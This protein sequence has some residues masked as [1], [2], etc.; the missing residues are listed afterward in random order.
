MLSR[1]KAFFAAFFAT[2][3]AAFFA[4]FFAAFRFFLR[5]ETLHQFTHGGNP[6]CLRF[7]ILH[8]LCQNRIVQA[9]CLW[10]EEILHQAPERRVVLAVAVDVDDM[11]TVT[12]VALQLANRA[13]DMV[14]RQ[15]RAE[16]VMLRDE[17]DVRLRQLAH[18][19]A[20]G[21]H[22]AIEHAAVVPRPPRDRPLAR[23]L[24]LAVIEL[25]RRIH[26]K[27]VEPDAAPVEVLHTLL[28]RDALHLDI[29]SR[30]DEPQD[31]IHTGNVPVETGG[32]KGIVDETKLLQDG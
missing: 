6:L 15:P 27:N 13:V 23:A 7:E 17:D 30:K 8:T 2:F 9:L 20:L 31:E 10:L 11:R 29:I 21:Q 22:A 4:T 28:R 26:C 24:H 14:K 3:F 12:E 25:P 18:R 16:R 19:R 1:R 5:A 32:E